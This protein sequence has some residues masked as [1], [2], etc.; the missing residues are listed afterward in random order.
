MLISLLNNGSSRPVAVVVRSRSWVDEVLDAG[1]SMAVAVDAALTGAVHALRSGAVHALWSGTE[2]A[3]ARI[4]GPEADAAVCTHAHPATTA[5][6]TVLDT[7]LSGPMNAPQFGKKY[8]RFQ[9]WKV[10][11]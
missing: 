3:E 7:P 11:T 1:C 2:T 6:A 5:T 4:T 9:R 10:A 8:A